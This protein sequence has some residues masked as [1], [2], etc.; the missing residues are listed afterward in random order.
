M[1]NLGYPKALLRTSDNATNSGAAHELCD[2]GA[3]SDV[4][5]RSVVAYGLPSAPLNPANHRV[6]QAS[7][8]AE[9]FDV[10]SGFEALVAPEEK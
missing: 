9:L 3:T 1:I 2:A 10:V 4:R 7:I 5:R 6:R 8:D